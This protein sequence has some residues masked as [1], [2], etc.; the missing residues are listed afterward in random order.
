MRAIAA[1]L[2]RLHVKT[3][4]GGSTWGPEAAGGHIEASALQL[5]GQGH[6]RPCGG[7]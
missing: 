7:R 5:T 4:R 1:R 2:E 3:A 6:D